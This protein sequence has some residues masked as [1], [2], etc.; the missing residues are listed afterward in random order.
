MLGAVCSA[1]DGD[2]SS[3]AKSGLALCGGSGQDF[4]ARQAEEV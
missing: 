1:A 4:L 2:G 3:V